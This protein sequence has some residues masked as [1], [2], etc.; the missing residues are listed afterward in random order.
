MDLAL[1]YSFQVHIKMQLS[2]GLPTLLAKTDSHFSWF[3]VVMFYK[4][5]VITE[6]VNM[7]PL[8]LEEYGTQR[9]GL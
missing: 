8:L 4:V 5:A 1:K 2:P 3:E 7:E 9:L 6:L